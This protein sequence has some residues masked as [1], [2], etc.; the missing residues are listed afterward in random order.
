[1]KFEITGSETGAQLIKQL[2]GLRALARLY[3]RLHNANRANRKGWQD[4]LKEYPGNQRIEKRA[5]EGIAL[6][7]ER[8]LEIR[9]DGVWLG[10]HLSAL[11]GELDKKAPRSAVFDA[12]NVGTKDRCSAEVQEYGDTTINLIAVLALEN[13]AT[14]SEDIEIQPLNWCCTQALMHAMR[15]NREMDKAAHDAANE[16]FNGAF[17]DFQ[18]RTPMEYLTGRAV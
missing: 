1:M 2:V 13:S 3:A 8:L 11:C 10:Q 18:E 16:V 15:T 14:G 9:F 4:L 5:A 7:N 12:L 17:G 6:A